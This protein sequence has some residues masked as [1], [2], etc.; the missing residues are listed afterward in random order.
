M[1]PSIQLYSGHY[2]NFLNPWESV[3]NITIETLVR[4]LSQVNRFTGHT[5]QPYSVA[6]HSVL[7]HEIVSESPYLNATEGALNY[8]LFHDA[9]ECV[10]GDVS[11][12]LKSILPDYR[13]LERQ[14]AKAFE[15]KFCGHVSDEDRST[16]KVADLMALDVE[17]RCLM[18]AE[19]VIE[20]WDCLRDLPPT[21]SFTTPFRSC[22]IKSGWNIRHVQLW[23]AKLMREV[24]PSAA[25]G[26]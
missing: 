5:K 24:R 1:K 18:L 6:Q 8:A 16:V 15:E 25:E 4:S 20:K 2:F 13:L 3:N 12:P 21:E 7:V 22:E 19:N 17:R 14:V 26:E 9:H 23:L 11:S 10:V